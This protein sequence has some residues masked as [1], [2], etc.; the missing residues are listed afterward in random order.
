M[1]RLA[2]RFYA[3]TLW[4]L[5]SLMDRRAWRLEDRAC[6]C[7]N[8]AARLRRRLAWWSDRADEVEREACEATAQGWLGDFDAGDEAPDGPERP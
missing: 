7:E 2:W 4:K 8:R 1:R 3:V 5:H 6:R